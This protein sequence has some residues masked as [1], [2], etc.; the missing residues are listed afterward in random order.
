MQRGGFVIPFIIL[1]KERPLQFRDMM[2]SIEA[3]TDM[4][5][6]RLIVCDNASIHPEMVSYLNELERKYTIIRNKE[7]NC[8]YGLNPGLKLV[9][10]DYLI[11]SDPDIRLNSAMPKDWPLT[12]KLTLEK[13]QIPKVGV[14]LNLWWKQ[15]NLYNRTIRANESLY[16]CK[17]ANLAFVKQPTYWAAIDT[18]LAMYRSDT[19]LFWKKGNL[20]FD[21]QNGLGGSGVVEQNYN[22][23]YNRECIRIGGQFTCEH[24]GWYAEKK[25]LPDY[26]FYKAH[27]VT[28]F[29]S[30]LKNMS[31]FVD[32]QNDKGDRMRRVEKFIAETRK[33]LPADIP[34]DDPRWRI[35]SFR[36][37]WK[38][39]H[40]YAVNYSV[41]S[42]DAH[43]QLSP[44][45]PPKRM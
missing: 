26:E 15:E 22:P 17:P 42:E 41:P 11:I 24:L 29:S 40:G 39:A 27:S 33:N 10:T 1:T 38:I 6:V 31:A 14:A 9:D 28:R 18:T 34:V 12:M 7:N 2:A 16:W 8:F 19:F 23:K 45:E 32:L 21:R 4:S 36:N 37:K 43:Y 13:L 25:Y 44:N 5:L 20:F 3:N 35:P 30:T